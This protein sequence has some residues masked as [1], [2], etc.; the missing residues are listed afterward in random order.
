M[1]YQ[2]GDQT[3]DDP[4]RW[5]EKCDFPMLVSWLQSRPWVHRRLHLFVD[6]KQRCKSNSKRGFVSQINW[7][8]AMRNQIW[9]SA[10]GPC[11]IHFAFNVVLRLVKFYNYAKLASISWIWCFAIKPFQKSTQDLNL[12]NNIILA[13]YLLRSE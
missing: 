1:E 10:C 5:W 13:S 4:T 6:A 8:L 11:A 7:R 12:I 2:L 9:L 3:H